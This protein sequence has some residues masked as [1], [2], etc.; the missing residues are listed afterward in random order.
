MTLL[1]SAT[2]I[3]AIALLGALTAPAMADG[4]ED[5][6]PVFTEE[7]LNDPAV[8]ARGKEIWEEQC[9]FCHGKN[10]YPG[11]APRLKP[12]KYTPDFVYKR[13]TKGYR[14]MPSWAE[15]YNHEERMSVAAWV[16]S[17]DFSN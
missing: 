11:K 5:D 10:A 7:F 4:T 1:R 15:V 3:A 2:A 6:Q 14:G 16:K 12:R 8:L 13:V 9:Q 17:K